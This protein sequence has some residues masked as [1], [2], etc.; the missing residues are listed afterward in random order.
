MAVAFSGICQSTAFSVMQDP[1]KLA[2]KDYAEGNYVAAIELFENALAK[3]S[4]N[5]N[6]QLKLARCYYLVKDYKKSISNY[7]VLLK[8]PDSMLSQNDLYYYA[9]AH[10]A[11]QH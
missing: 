7:D 2:D 4:D 1:L 8:T 11:L 3:N 10:T 6:I 5:H 9:Q